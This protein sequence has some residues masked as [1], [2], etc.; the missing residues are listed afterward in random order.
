MQRQIAILF[1]LM[2][3][4]ASLRLH[5]QNN[6]SGVINASLTNKAGISLL[7]QSD[8]TGVALIGAS[9]ST[10]AL[11][12]GRVSRFMAAPSQGVTLSRT[13]S[14]FSVSSTFAT[15]VD[16]GGVTSP[17]YSLSASLLNVPGLFTYS[18]DGKPLSD[19]NTVQISNGSPYKQNVAHTVSITIPA[20]AP[21]GNVSNTIN[22]IATA[23]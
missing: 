18:I 12:F 21:A 3:S 7:F 6:A 9:T 23:N 4:V 2:L 20:G 11:D 10:A 19:A 1:V 17:G 16:I 22:F 8:S 5:A 14:A 15:Y 13:S